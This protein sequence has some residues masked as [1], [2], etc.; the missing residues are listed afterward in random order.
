MLAFILVWLVALSLGVGYLFLILSRVFK[1]KDRG[2]KQ[3]IFDTLGSN[4]KLIISVEGLSSDL[5]KLQHS[6]KGAYQKTAIVQ[7]NPFERLGGEQSYCLA[8]INQN[9]SGVVLTFLYTK[10]GV[11]TYMKEVVGGEAKGADLSKEE[12]AAIHKAIVTE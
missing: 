5:K 1:T 7:F 2:L 3:A 6:F 9:N 12:R 10:E 4:Q 11:R 8:V